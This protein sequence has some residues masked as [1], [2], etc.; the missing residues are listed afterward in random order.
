MGKERKN[1]D[2]DKVKSKK[3]MSD[4]HLE[5]YTQQYEEKKADVSTMV[6]AGGRKKQSLNG[7]WHYAID[8]YDTCLRQKWFLEKYFDERDIP[9]LSIIPLTNG[10]LCSFLPAG[11]QWKKSICCMKEVWFLPENSLIGK[12]MRRKRLS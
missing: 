3:Y 2:T 11:T 9:C 1:M 6:F 5:D 8:Q 10:R 4:I 12:R 7:Q